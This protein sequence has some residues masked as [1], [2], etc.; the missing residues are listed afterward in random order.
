MRLRRKLPCGVHCVHPAATFKIGD[1][2]GPHFFAPPGGR[3]GP[4]WA[5]R[6]IA[7]PPDPENFGRGGDPRFR[8]SLENLR[9]SRS[10]SRGSPHIGENICDIL[11]L[12]LLESLDDRVPG[13]R[14]RTHFPT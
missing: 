10:L 3:F 9:G 6:Q 13:T 7:A 12:T 8:S 1:P 11:R 5:G 14:I 4:P 2:V